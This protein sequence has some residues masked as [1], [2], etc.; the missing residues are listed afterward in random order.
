MADEPQP[1][2]TVV[3][4]MDLC[5]GYGE[6]VKA[7]PGFF[8]LDDDGFV[9][10]DDPNVPEGEEGRVIAAVGKCPKDALVLL[11]DGVPVDLP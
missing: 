5:E 6:C 2:L 4:D 11:A 7:A 9:Q 3:A 8:S 10:I 1:K